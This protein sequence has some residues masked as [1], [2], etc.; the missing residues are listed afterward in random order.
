MKLKFTYFISVASVVTV[1]LP[2]TSNTSA[3]ATGIVN[4]DFS[5]PLTVGWNSSGDVALRGTYAGGPV[6]GVGQAMLTSASSS[7]LDDP[8]N[9][10]ISGNNVTPIADLETYLGIPQ[11]TL[12]PAN[13]IFG[14]VEG[15]ALTQSF[16]GAV[17]EHL[18]FKWK[19]LTNDTT[20]TDTTNFPGL[21]D[22][23]YA[24][25]LLKTATTQQLWTLADTSSSLLGTANSGSGYQRETPFQ[26]F[27]FV[28]S[29]TEIY[30]ISFGVLDQ[31]NSALTSALLVN[32]VQ[33]QATVPEPS[34]SLALLLLGT[35]LGLTKKRS[36][37]K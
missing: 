2:L 24:F 36:L 21:Q 28:L 15:S 9:F 26:S 17:G 29:T 12:T 3:Q 37:R 31:G 22:A 8:T 13:A 27:N 7:G 18:S 1:L 34:N 33:A 20:Q 5:S 10:N 19:F 14:P 25:L 23:D 11:G 4:G 32:N 16:S 30:T 35:G 6:A